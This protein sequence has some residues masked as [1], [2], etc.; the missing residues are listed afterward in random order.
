VSVASRFGKLTL[1]RQVFAP[2]D[3]TGHVIPGN[4]VLPA[5]HGIIIT[6]GLQ[7]W[8]C[9][10]P[11]D[12]SFATASRLL[13][14]QP[15]AEPLLS[16]TTLR[17]LVREHG[18]AL[19]QAELVQAQAVLAR[20]DLA[21]LRP[22]LTVVP[23]PRGR[24]AWPAELTA[25][26]D[27]ALAAG[28]ERPPEGVLAADWAR[29]LAQHHHHPACP[30]A[31]LRTLGPQVQPDEVLIVPDEVCTRKTSGGFWELR[32]ARVTT[33]AGTRYVSGT[34][35]TFLTV[36]L[37][38]VLLCASRDQRL[39]VLADGARWIRAW[40]VSLQERWPATRLI[41][42]WFHLRKRCSEWASMFCCGRHAKKALLRTVYRQ[43]WRGE[44]DAAIASLEAYRPEAR[45]AEWLDKLISYLDERR[46]FIPD[47]GERRRTREYIGSGQVE[48]A[49]D[50]IVAQRQK[51]AGM[52]WSLETSDALAALRTLR[53]NGEWDAYWCH[54][55]LPSLVAT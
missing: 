48:K 4:A 50:Q 31:Q 54:R 9:L 25:A 3:P 8:A 26:V 37:A 35:E 27:A 2:T 24:A 13:G 7:E 51:G 39:L 29:V 52:R 32:T 17:N 11:Q 6:R 49:N 36:L 1:Q 14:W 21:D 46:P 45:Q 19:R 23:P 41:L 20:P 44:V 22:H 12:L 53:L 47:Y 16:D 43:L 10:L 38:V 33:S 18:Q 15:Q 55:R 42:D 40:V 28:V 30:A 34:G 5:H